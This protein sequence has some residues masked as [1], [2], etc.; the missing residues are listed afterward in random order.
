MLNINLF[1]TRENKRLP[2]FPSL[3]RP[4]I[5]GSRFTQCALK[6]D[7]CSPMHTPPV[8]LYQVQQK[9]RKEPCVLI[10]IAPHFPRQS[11]YPILVDIPR[12]F[13]LMENMLTQERSDKTYQSQVSKS[14]SMEIW[15]VYS[16][17][18]KEIDSLVNS[19]VHQNRL[20]CKLRSTPRKQGESQ[21]WKRKTRS[22]QQLVWLTCFSTFSLCERV[23]QLYPS[24]LR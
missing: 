19:G 5:T 16:I 2:V 22:L 6:R 7:G 15:K 9:V 14:R 3:S 1:A 18:C 21:H 23:G 13:A 20:S 8:L 17:F 24:A 11:W 10:L 4:F 12:Q